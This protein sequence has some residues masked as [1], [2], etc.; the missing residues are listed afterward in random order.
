M[1]G[2]LYFDPNCQH[3]PSSHMLTHVP[4]F[5]EKFAQAILKSEWGSRS[6]ALLYSLLKS[7][8]HVLRGVYRFSQDAKFF[9]SADSIIGQ[10][11]MYETK[12]STEPD[13][14]RENIE[15]DSLEISRR[16]N[17]LAILVKRKQDGSSFYFLDCLLEKTWYNL[18]HYAQKQRNK[19]ESL[20]SMR[21]HQLHQL[22]LLIILIQRHT[23]QFRGGPQ[24]II[25]IDK[26]IPKINEGDLAFLDFGDVDL[27]LDLWITQ[28]EQSITESSKI[29]T[30]SR[31]LKTH[32]RQ[33]IRLAHTS[34]QLA[35]KCLYALIANYRLKK[36][37]L[38][39]DRFFKNQDQS[40]V[41]TPFSLTKNTFRHLQPPKPLVKTTPAVVAA[42]Q[43][44]ARF[45]A[46][47]F[48]G[49]MPLFIYSP[50]NPDKM[51]SLI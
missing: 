17:E 29:H 47:Y 22:D 37:V 7:T 3:N 13:T 10:K 21:R 42:L 19:L 24:C 35:H 49:R 4:R 20:G 6:L 14:E 5:I 2:I 31:L 16:F 43:S 40:D 25:P 1:L 32:R 33:M 27:A 51:P 45:M 50:T 18:L 39:F 12:V 28:L 34:T 8:E 46:R 26:K 15:T 23:L 36:L 38:F 48:I 44:F 41:F 30:R 11:L 9:L